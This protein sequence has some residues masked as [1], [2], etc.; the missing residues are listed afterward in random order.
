MGG[1]VPPVRT[2]H[3]DGDAVIVQEVSDEEGGGKDLVDDEKPAGAFHLEK[4]REGGREGGRE[5]RER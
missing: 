1:A 4:R 3:E 2:V 5:R